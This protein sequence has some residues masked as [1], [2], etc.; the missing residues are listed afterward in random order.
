MQKEGSGAARSSAAHRPPKVEAKPVAPKVTQFS[1]EP[2]SIQRGQSSTLRWAVSGEATSITIDQ[3]IGTVQANGNRRVFSRALPPPTRLPPADPGAA[4][5]SAPP[6]NRQCDPNHP[7]P[8]TRRR[9]KRVRRTLE[10][11]LAAE[12]QDAFF[13]YDKNDVREDARNVL[14][15]NADAIKSILGEFPQRQ[16]RGGRPLRRTRLG[17]VQPRTGRPARTTSAKEFPGATGRLPRTV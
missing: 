13:D 4:A 11:R 16:H 6:A 9:R 14:T 10:Q 12:V 3:G 15:R 5:H 2:T 8:A 1:A 17:R 7:A